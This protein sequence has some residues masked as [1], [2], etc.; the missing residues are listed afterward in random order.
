MLR[1]FYN[2]YMSVSKDNVKLFCVEFASQISLNTVFLVELTS[3]V[4]LATLKITKSLVVSE[5]GLSAAVALRNTA[6]SVF[7]MVIYVVLK[8]AGIWQYVV[9]Y[10]KKLDSAMSALSYW[11]VLVGRDSVRIFLLVNQ[12]ET[13]L[14]HNKFKA[15]LVNLFSGCTAFEI[16]NMIS[17]V[18]GWSY[19]ISQSPDSGCH[20]CFVLVMFGSQAD[21]DLAVAKTG[22]LAVDCKVALFPF[23][24]ASKV[25][26]SCFIG[27]LS[28]AK[29]SASPVMSELSPLVASTPSVAVV[30]P[31]VGSKLDSLKKQILDLAALIKFIVKPVDFLVVLLEKDLLSMKYVSN[32]FA[33]LLVGVSKDIACLRSEVDFGNMDYDNMQAATPS[34][35]SKNTV[36]CV[37]ALWQM[38]GVEV[39]SSVESTRLFF[40]G[41]IFD[42]KNLNSVIE[43]ICGLELFLPSI[44]LA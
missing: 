18:G 10:F 43:K 27:F 1:L 16:S 24:K 41:F 34:L 29:A 15:K 12:N 39:R 17:Q 3:S 2:L 36:E 32:N 38:S 37:I 23:L 14:F 9:V 22:Y 31:A 44:V 25:F 35:L 40:S 20:L 42:S 13:I 30:D 5:F 28:Y 21:L 6:L 33:N 4:Y 19:F 11:S 26:K 7:G 8:P